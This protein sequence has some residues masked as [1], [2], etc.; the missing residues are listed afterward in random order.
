MLGCRCIWYTF[1]LS[2]CPNHD[3]NCAL[4]KANALTPELHPELSSR[5]YASLALFAGSF[6]I[7]CIADYQK[8]VWRR[9]RDKKQH[10]ERD[11]DEH[12]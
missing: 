12:E 11:D 8:V 7:E 9:A 3:L 2:V 10:D 6:A 1:Q 5:D 4:F